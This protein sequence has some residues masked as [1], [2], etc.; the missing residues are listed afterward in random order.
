MQATHSAFAHLASEA[1]TQ[2]S[3]LL[4]L[5]CIRNG[6]RVIADGRAFGTCVREEEIAA[7]LKLAL[8]QLALG[9]CRASAIVHAAA[10]ALNGRAVLLAGPAG[11]GKTTL[12]AGLMLDGGEVLADDIAVIAEDG[13]SVRA[14]PLPLCIKRGAWPVLERLLPELGNLP[15][16]RRADGQDVRYLG[17]QSGGSS[18]QARNAVR[19]GAIIFPRYQPG[20]ALDARRLEPVEAF[21]ALLPQFYPLA[22]RFDRDSMDRLIQLLVTVPC[23]H[24]SYGDLAHGVGAVREIAC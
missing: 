23:F 5:L 1:L 13:A 6:Y 9:Q 4:K 14:M 19:I 8:T 24:L 11:S 10:V 22:N 2:P 12:L 16:H 21:E 20:A 15:V 17:P 18:S 3:S 7:L